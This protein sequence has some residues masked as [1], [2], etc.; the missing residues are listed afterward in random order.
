MSYPYK[1]KQR[2]ESLIKSLE[3]L[4][5]SDP[6]QQVQGFAVPVLAAALDDVKQALP[7]DPV[8]EALVELVSADAIGSGDPIRAADMLI[9]ARQ[10][11][12]AIGRRPVFV[13]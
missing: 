12:A 5:G 7:N 1:A 10:L 8:V 9:I 2:V 4:V 6:E 11:D 3:T 13:A